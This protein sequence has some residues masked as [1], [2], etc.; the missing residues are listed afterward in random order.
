M[1]LF[2]RQCFV[3]VHVTIL[4]LSCDAEYYALPYSLAARCSKLM[5]LIQDKNV[6]LQFSYK[7]DIQKEPRERYFGFDHMPKDKQLH[8]TDACNY[9]KIFSGS[10]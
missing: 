8:K 5:L 9:G 7:D 10:P 4:T 2:H 3:G 1:S 6:H